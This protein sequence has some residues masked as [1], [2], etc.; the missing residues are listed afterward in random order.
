MWDLSSPIR[1][2]THALWHGTCSVLTTGPP[3]NYP[4]DFNFKAVYKKENLE[5]NIKN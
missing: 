3:G 1:D 4:L 5:R 2:Q